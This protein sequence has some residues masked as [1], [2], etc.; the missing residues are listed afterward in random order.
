MGE[1]LTAAQMRAKEN[2]AIQGGFAHGLTLMERAGQGVVDATFRVIGEARDGFMSAVVL[3]GPGNNGGDGFVIARVLHEMGWQVQ[4]YLYGDAGRLPPDARTMYDRWVAIGP[5]S[6]I[7][8]AVSG[9]GD[10]PVLLFDAM[11]GIGINRPIPA[12]CA[13]AFEAIC[14]RA[15]GPE[16]FVVAVDC[17]SGMDVDT[18]AVLVGPD[19]ANTLLERTDL[20]VTFHAPKLGHYLTEVGRQRPAVVDIGLRPEDEVVTQLVGPCGGPAKEWLQSVTALGAGGHKY[21]RGHVLV[22]GGGVGK[23]GA[24]RMAARSALRVGA[25]LVTLTVPPEAIPE[26]AAQL[27]A[28]ML[29]PLDGADALREMLADKRL[30]SVC[31]GPGLGVGDRTRA[32]VLAALEETAQD[33]R[34][35]VLDADA[36]GSFAEDPQAL[37]EA[38]HAGVVITPHE[39]EFAR[40]FPDLAERTRHSDPAATGLGKVESTCRAAERLG[41]TVLLKG[42]ATVLADPEGRSMIHA[43]LYDRA[44]PWLG[45]AGAGDVLAGLIA[46]LSAGEQ[47]RTHAPID[48]AGAAAWLHVECARQ[49]GP[50]LIAEDLPEQLP[51]VFR[52]LGF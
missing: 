17:P 27:N 2:K 43:A 28:I 44:A 7:K 39:G 8:D 5:V 45:T 15:T 38:C 51:A 25:G 41:A 18:G 52:N 33:G 13:Q 12:V 48:L 21:D 46:G 23:G 22:L 36:L 6:P 14:T 1:I 37:F 11:F 49:F 47:A 4:V 9:Q 40:L 16:C 19:G 31:L 26:N 10:R 50:G 34:R 24:A 42:E 20:C 3:C 30:S 32:L 35:V 29:R